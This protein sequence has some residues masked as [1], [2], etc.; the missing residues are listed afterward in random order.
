MN[1]VRQGF[2]KLSYYKYKDRDTDRQ[3]YVHRPVA[4][5]HHERARSNDLAG[6]S[7]AL[8]QALPIALLCF[9]NSV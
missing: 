7:T 6:R 2:R 8:A 3:T 1:F 4:A 5:L 9:G